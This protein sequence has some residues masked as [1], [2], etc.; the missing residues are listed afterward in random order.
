VS[1]D[2]P[3]NAGIPSEYVPDKN[4][5]IRLYRRIADLRSLP[6][7]DA[8]F[9][10]FTD[11]FGI[12][13]KPVRNLLFQLKIKLSAELAEI[14][15]VTVENSQIVLRFRDEQMPSDLPPVLP[16]HVRIGKTALWMAYKS[17]PNWRAELLEL[18]NTLTA[19]K[20]S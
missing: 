14:S 4:M 12:P 13:P 7:I 3:I 1:V 10:E 8:I 20:V 18:F 16:P 15:S 11:R 5:R 17:L 9:E 6:E 19:E 2:L